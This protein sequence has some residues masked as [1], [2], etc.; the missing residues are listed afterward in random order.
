ML[1]TFK[2]LRSGKGWESLIWGMKERPSGGCSSET[3]PHP[4]DMN[5]NKNLCLAP[6][7][8]TQLL[9]LHSES[10]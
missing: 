8:T 10:I 1:A 6:F 2:V 9:G 5:N 4:I 3:K 7:S